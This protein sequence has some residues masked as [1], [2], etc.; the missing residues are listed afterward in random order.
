[1]ASFVLAVQA[2]LDAT[3]AYT[4]IRVS[5]WIE[6]RIGLTLLSAII[7]DAGP[8]GAVQRSDAFADTF[9]TF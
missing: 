9:R 3:R 6:R 4:F 8:L 7:A 2:A 1:M 5:Q